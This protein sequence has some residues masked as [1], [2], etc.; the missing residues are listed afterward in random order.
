MLILPCELIDHNGK[1]LQEIV[2]KLAE[3]WQLEAEF[4]TW[5]KTA[6][7]FC[8]TL[9]DRI[10]TGYPGAEAAAKIC[11]ELGYHDQLLTTAELFHLWVIEAPKGTSERFPLHQTGLNVKWVEDLTP[12]AP[13]KYGFSTVPIPPALPFLTWLDLTMCGK[14]PKISC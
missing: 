10:V 9:V 7:V 8:N 14:L 5:L 2:L 12:I 6:N 1:H 13:G 3:D 11:A 4:I